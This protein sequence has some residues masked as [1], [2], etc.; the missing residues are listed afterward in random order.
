VSPSAAQALWTMVIAD[1]RTREIEPSRHRKMAGSRCTRHA[2][3]AAQCDGLF[4]LRDQRLTAISR[5]VRARAKLDELFKR[6][7]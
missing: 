2:I 7:K 3:A 4:R 5:A 1:A 6:G